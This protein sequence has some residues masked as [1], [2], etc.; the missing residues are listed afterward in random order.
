M[1]INDVAKSLEVLEASLSKV[2]DGLEKA[3]AKFELL[4]RSFKVD[5]IR[6]IDSEFNKLARTVKKSGED[7]K[8]FRDTME[9]LAKSVE[10]LSQRELAGLYS[11][12]AK[13]QSGF[14]LTNKELRDFT[15]TLGKAY[16]DEAPNYARALTQVTDKFPQFLDKIR[17]GKT[18]V[19]TLNTVLK[20]GG[21][22][23]LSAY[24]ELVGKAGDKTK[25]E[26]GDMDSAVKKLESSLANF[27]TKV[28]DALSPV[29]RG[30]ADFVGNNPGIAA[31][32][33]LGATLYGGSKVFGS[34][35]GGGKDLQSVLKDKST[36]LR[37]E[38]VNWPASAAM[39]G[40]SGI[41]GEPYLRPPNGY[42]AQTFREKFYEAYLSK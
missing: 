22:E 27:K 4:E 28:G 7:F 2:G 34:F 20:E 23:A 19:G 39:G 32:A 3:G 37:V 29:V 13:T 9:Q 18:D 26:F 31:A 33:G 36:I 16:R 35:G 10:H 30:V 40:G 38:V 6:A 5:Y 41:G 17:Q 42:P 11:A 15:E 14:Q 24:M 12:L 8:S 1:A 21:R 25:K